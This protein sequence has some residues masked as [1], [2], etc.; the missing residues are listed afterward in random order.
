MLGYCLQMG[1][2]EGARHPGRARGSFAQRLRDAA[3]AMAT[4]EAW[5]AQELVGSSAVQV[6]QVKL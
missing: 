1:A 6:G 3:S 5:G 4:T 2:A